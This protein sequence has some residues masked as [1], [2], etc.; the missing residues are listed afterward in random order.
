MA[1]G[2]AFQ[3]EQRV[4]K[5]GIVYIYRPVNLFGSALEFPIYAKKTKLL[6]INT[7]GYTSIYVTPQR[8]LLFFSQKWGEL[9]SS[10]HD[11]FILEVHEGQEYYIKVEARLANQPP[12]IKLMD[13]TIGEKEI[14]KTKYQEPALKY[15]EG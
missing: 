6:S 10:E 12:G 4:D 9:S 7:G 13:K 11:A 1:V 14:I 2:P 15:I 5:Y 3:K 8:L